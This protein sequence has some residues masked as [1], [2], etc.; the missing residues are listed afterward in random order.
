MR[1]LRDIID[2][3]EAVIITAGAGMGVDTG[4]PDF[5][6]KERVWRAYPA[7]KRM[8][9]DFQ[10]M[11]NPEWFVK[12]PELA[13]A[14]YGHRLHQYN[15]TTPHAGFD[16]LLEYVTRKHDNYFVITSNV[17]G[18]FQKAGFDPDRIREKHGANARL[19]CIDGCKRAIWPVNYDDVVVDHET[20]TATRMPVC[21]CCGKIA[22]PNILMFGD[23]LSDVEQKQRASF[24][25]WFEAVH[26]QDQ[27]IVI[28][29]IGAGIDLPSIRR[30]SE[31]LA[32][33]K[34]THLIRINPRHCSVPPRVTS[35]KAA[36]GEGIRA[37]LQCVEGIPNER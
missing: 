31:S 32:V 1:E 34:N 28:I 11:A 27:Q 2:Q 37:L 22:R 25:A 23:W 20:F 15:A 5:R 4:L 19:Q 14:F 16:M 7:L 18:V 10:Q 12:R 35:I 33:H 29:A 13:W 17:D 30:L 36:G 9:L 24:S 21:P 6:G 26:Q 3:A 8:R